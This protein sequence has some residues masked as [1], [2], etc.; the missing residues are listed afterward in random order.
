VQKSLVAFK[1]VSQE[2]VAAKENLIAS[3]GQALQLAD[4]DSTSRASMVQ[5]Q[6][7]EMST[8]QR[9]LKETRAQAQA[10][11][12]CEIKLSKKL[13]QREHRIAD[14]EQVMLTLQVRESPCACC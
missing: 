14:L 11:G 7:G 13:R 4:R 2:E 9:E 6:V 12:K 8:L 3:L 10:R 1:A 5:R